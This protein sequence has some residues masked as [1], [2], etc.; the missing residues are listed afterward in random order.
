[1]VTIFGDVLHAQHRV[2]IITSDTA[3][4][5]CAKEAGMLRRVRNRAVLNKRLEKW[6]DLCKKSGYISFA[7]DSVYSDTTYYYVDFYAGECYADSYISVSRNAATAVREAGLGKFITDGKV[8]ATEYEDLAQ[9]IICYYENHGFPFVEVRLDSLEAA[10]GKLSAALAIDRHEFTIMDSVIVKGTAKVRPAYLYPYL[11]IRKRKAYSESTM[12]RVPGIVSEMPFAT[13]T[14]PSGVEFTGDKATLY[15]FLDKKKTSRFDG[16]MALIPEDER[17]GKVGFAGEVTLALKNIFGIGE[18]FDVEWRAPGAKSQN[19]N[20]TVEFP[21]LF[22]TPL[23]ADFHFTLNKTD[24]SYMNMNY[25]V[26]L[27]YS[28]LTNGS[29]KAYYEYTTSDVLKTS[30]LQISDNDINYMDY[31]KNMYGLV[32]SYYQLDYIFNPRKGIEMEFDVSAGQRKI[33]K[34]RNLDE[35][36]YEGIRLQSG[37]YLI[38][39]KI[40]GYIP[41]HKRWVLKLAS[42]AG[43]LFGAENLTNDLFKLGGMNSLRG[44][45]EDEILANAYL[46]A[47]VELRFLFAKIAYANIFTDAAWYERDLT[48]SYISDF[49]FGFG[50]GISFDTKAGIFFINYALGKQFNNPISFK[51]GKI[52]FGFAV[53]F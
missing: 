43:A 33:V 19:L 44:F 48:E 4:L 31:R 15:L 45:A 23:G 26:G 41:L 6:C 32:F 53:N 25:K 20:L 51:N 38:K 1:M 3:V 10:N 16:Y 39:G 42:N 50:A 29:L 28:F 40:C 5:G 30:L 12:R 9:K 8:A 18:S 11:G 2:S 22:R 17:T 52:H 36:E 14:S 7:I 47:T 34:N 46:T 35:S 27:R 37:N 21:Y 49:P 13:E 24:T